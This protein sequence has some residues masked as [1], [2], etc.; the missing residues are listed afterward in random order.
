M[1]KTFKTV[2]AYK[3]GFMATCS[4]SNHGPATH[5]AHDDVKKQV[6]PL[7]DACKADFDLSTGVLKKA[8]K[9]EKK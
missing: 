3:A 4:N 8:P 7:C 2:A 1:A 9:V 6:V 5:V